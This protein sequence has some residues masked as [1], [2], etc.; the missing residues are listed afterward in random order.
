MRFLLPMM[1]LLTGCFEHRETYVGKIIRIETS[2]SMKIVTLDTL[3][4][5]SRKLGAIGH[6]ELW[7]FGAD[8]QLAAAPLDKEVVI[9]GICD[10][11]ACREVVIRALEKE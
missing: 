1:L 6:G 2:G 3:A 11:W 4:N 7:L 10:G 9:S 8:E 5:N